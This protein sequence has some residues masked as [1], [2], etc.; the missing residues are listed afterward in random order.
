MN[1]HNS[2]PS[3]NT[4]SDTD[5]LDAYSQAVTS[6]VEQVG[7]SVVSIDI[8]R[9][10]RTPYMP[11]DMDG[12]GSGMVLAPEG[13]ILTNYHV[14]DKSHTLTVGFIDGRALPAKVVGSGWIN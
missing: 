4:P 12:A 7:P 14:V 10:V 2:L 5:L 1:N 13:Y 11:V 9:R 3:V 6:V 8:R